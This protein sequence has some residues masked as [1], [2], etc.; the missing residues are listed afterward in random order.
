MITVLKL[1]EPEW[2][3]HEIC[4]YSRCVPGDEATDALI[5]ECMEE[6]APLLTYSV[7]FDTVPVTRK[8]ENVTCIADFP[9]MSAKLERSLNGCSEAVLF[10]ATVGL[11][12]DRLIMK[13]GYISPAKASVFQ[14]IGAERIESLCN[15]FC[16]IRNSELNREGKQLLPRVSPGY[17]DIPLEL[18]RFLLPYLDSRRK[19]GLTINSGMIMSPS[20]SVTAIAGICEL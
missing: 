16:G 7:C 11:G 4:R 1:K 2:D 6:A 18:Q 14:G 19:I 10:A 20:K 9:V 3:F 15:E 8:M 17:G 5:R 12:I 13:Y